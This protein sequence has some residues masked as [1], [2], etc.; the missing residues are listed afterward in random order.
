M[1]VIVLAGG[2]STERNVSLVSGSMVYK[3]LKSYGHEVILIDVY[4][5]YKGDITDLFRKEIDW[6]ADIKAVSKENPDLDE[7]RRLRDDENGFFGSNV[8]NLCKEADVAFLALHGVNGE[9]GKLQACL[10][11]LGIPYTG[12]DSVS[13]AMS[14]DKGI[15]KDIFSAYDIPTPKGIRLK[16]D[17]NEIEK[18]PY[19]CIVKAACGG[20]SVGVTIANNDEEYKIAKEIGFSYGDEVV[21]EQYIKGREFSVGVLDGNALPIIEISPKEGF[22]DYI[23]KY[24]AGS[25]VEVCP[26]PLNE[27]KTAEMQ[28]MAIDVFKALRLKS[29]ARMDFLMDSNENI[30]CLEANTLPGMTPTS[31]LPQEAAAAGISF[32]ELCDWIV[33]SALK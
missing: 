26:A 7:I 1:K 20:S 19:P 27:E 31:L 18:I 2:L 13:S 10:E 21:I 24:Q 22:Y 30:Y 5:G 33:K 25:T 14:M 9:D 28:K 4:L 8:I 16:R 32:E 12:T 6:T 29:Y 15:T 11:L 23:N 3:A 17:E